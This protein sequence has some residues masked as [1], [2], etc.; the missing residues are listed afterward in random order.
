MDD[1]K[2][3]LALAFQARSDSGYS[4]RLT[5]RSLSPPLL[6]PRAQHLHEAWRQ[7]AV[8]RG[9]LVAARQRPKVRPRPNEIIGL[10]EQDP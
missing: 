10:G 6:Q 5:A 4:L 7:E 2:Q 3:S 8:C 1:L 9:A